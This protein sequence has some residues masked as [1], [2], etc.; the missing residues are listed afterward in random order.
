MSFVSRYRNSVSWCAVCVGGSIVGPHGV[1]A[2][3]HIGFFG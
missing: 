3:M 2:F 1:L